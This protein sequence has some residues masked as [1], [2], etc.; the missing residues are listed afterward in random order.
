MKRAGHACHPP[1]AERMA[2]QRAGEFLW[3]QGLGYVF[4]DAPKRKDGFPFVRV[5]CP[6]C[7]GDLPTPDAGEGEE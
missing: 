5:D 3:V 7:G 6:W 4:V 2:S 1:C